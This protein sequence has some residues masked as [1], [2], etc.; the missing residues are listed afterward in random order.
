MPLS[1]VLEPPDVLRVLFADDHALVRDGM[2]PFLEM[3]DPDIDLREAED[4]DAALAL[5]PATEPPDLAILDLHMPGMNQF[6]GIR[7]LQTAHPKTRIAVVSGYYDKRIID[8]VIAA[9]ARGFVPKTSTGKTLL[10]ALRIIL[11]GETYVPHSLMADGVANPLPRASTGATGAMRAL[12][13]LS[14]RE[15]GIL[16]MVIDGKTNKEIG[17]ELDLSE[18]TIKGHLRL[19]YKKM[20]A[21]NRADAVR[22][23]LDSGFE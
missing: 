16:R 11:E 6:D 20:G 23:A 3:L 4:L 15:L 12:E 8:G 22:I 19:A 21:V 14:E 10:G 1:R 5:F 7:R 2:R 9:G 17:R 13:T 18:I